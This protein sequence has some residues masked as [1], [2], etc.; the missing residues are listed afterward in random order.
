MVFPCVPVELL[1]VTLSDIV[2]V[3]VGVMVFN[4]V[5]CVVHGI[6]ESCVIV[7]VNA[8]CKLLGLVS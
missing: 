3:S 4:V 6:F 5:A 8:L 1:L 2:Y 7:G